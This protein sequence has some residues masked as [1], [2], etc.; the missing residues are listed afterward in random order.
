MSEAIDG[1]R[2]FG[3]IA[4][5]GTA[6]SLL[7]TSTIM[8]Q[9]ILAVPALAVE[10]G[11]F[12]V[13]SALKKTKQKRLEE[14]KQIMSQTQNELYKRIENSRNSDLPISEQIERVNRI[15][16]V[17]N[18]I[19]EGERKGIKYT[20]T[21]SKDGS[22]SIESDRY[23]EFKKNHPNLKGDKLNEAYAKA[24]NKEYIKK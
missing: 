22:M 24:Y 18:T 21:T 23:I 14:A 12:A 10:L 19:A 5:F 3:G 8:S 4:G 16:N 20:A 11:V 15:K 6:A 17:S 7:A 9:P 1:K 13:D 2:A